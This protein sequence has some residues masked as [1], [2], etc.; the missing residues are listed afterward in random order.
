MAIRVAIN[1]FGRIGRNV[2]KVLSQRNGIDVVA[3][4]DLADNEML[5][6]LLKY[7]TVTGRFFG[8]AT[9]KATDEAIQVGDQTIKV[10]SERE[11]ANLPWGDL[12]IDVTV[13]STGIFRTPE[14]VEWHLQAGAKKVVLTVPPK[15]ELD[16][17]VVLGVNDDTIN[18]EQKTLSNASCTTNCLAPIA[19]ILHDSFGID[20]GIMTTVHAY[21]NDQH[22]A[23]LPH[24]DPRRARAAAQ[25]IIPT[26]T[27]AARAVG[28]VLPDLAGKLD[29]LS[30]RVPV[31]NGSIVD[32]VV[33]L[34]KEV[35]AENINAAVKEAAEGPMKG[36]VEYTEDPIVSSDIIM[37]PHSAIFDSEA[38]MVLGD[39]G[40]SAKVLA[41][42]DNE[43]GY[44]NRVGDLIE[45]ISS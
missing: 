36:I 14:Q 21:N 12:E 1:G 38:T 20:H 13:E 27:G 17:M 22:L 26:T 5:A 16:N 9:V 3:I 2:F 39:S 30:L 41:W 31:I 35:T 19:K 6:H 45:R 33:E 23:D 7:D 8:D 4:N 18:P 44:S 25:N 40:S 10:F 32:L 15:G 34:Q 42:Y 37:N 24:S 11:P 43:W 28:K 29:G